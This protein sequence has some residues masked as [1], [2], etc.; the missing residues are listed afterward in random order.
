MATQEEAVKK[1]RDL[2]L[3]H[4]RTMIAYWNDAH[5]SRGDQKQRLE[6]LAFSIMVALDGGAGSLPSGYVVA[7]NHSPSVDIAG[8][9]HELLFR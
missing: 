4:V 1:E 3:G 6:G 9:L 8:S 2:F 7:P 5:G